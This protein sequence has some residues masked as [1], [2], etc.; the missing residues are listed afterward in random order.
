MKKIF[1]FDSDSFSL[2]KARKVISRPFWWIVA[3]LVVSVGTAVGVYFAFALIFSTDVESQLQKEIRM[4]ESLYD[5]LLSREALVLDAT[6]NI[7]HKDNA[8][9]NLIFHSEAPASNPTS[10]ESLDYAC[11]TIPDGKINRYTGDKADSLLQRSAQIEA[12]FAKIY[13]ALRDSGCVSI[14]MRLPLEKVN[15]SQIGAGVGEK[16]DP[17]YK[18]YVRHEGL[19]FVVSAS[20]KVLASAPGVVVEV[21][22]SKKFGRMVE[23]SHEGGYTT[24]YAHLESVAVRAGQNVVAGQKIGAVGMSGKAFA[25]HLHYEVRHSSR[26][27]DPVNYLFASLSASEYSNFLFMSANTVQSMD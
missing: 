15:Y 26:E 19:D 18:A 4:Y 10:A 27:L 25:P 6:A 5:E 13:A 11:D 24:I 14:P 8:V 12:N 3:F 9:Y 23:I 7:Q 1:D 16:L 17:F 21:Q 20:S 22:N 2:G